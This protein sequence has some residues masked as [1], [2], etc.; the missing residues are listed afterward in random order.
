VPYRR[1]SWGGGRR[2]WSKSSS[3]TIA[4]RRIT[5]RP[6]LILWIV[7]ACMSVCIT[8]VVE[9]VLCL[10]KINNKNSY[11]GKNIYNKVI[12]HFYT[13]SFE[14][15]KLKTHLC[16]LQLLHWNISNKKLTPICFQLV[17]RNIIIKKLTPTRFKW[18][19]GIFQIN[20]SLLYVCN[21]I[22]RIPQT[23][24]S[25]LYASIASLQYF[26]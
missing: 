21:C 13:F 3:W 4:G 26:K 12:T 19:I 6:F 18:F 7:Y 24:N 9:K 8:G 17:H 10:K 5:V 25:L 14:Y 2:Q 22:I 11:A 20:I 23:K 1:Y 15:L 16:M